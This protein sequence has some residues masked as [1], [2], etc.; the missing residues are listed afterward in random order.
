MFVA[1][2]LSGCL[3]G[4]GEAKDKK[5]GG[6]AEPTGAGAPRVTITDFNAT[7]N[8]STPIQIAWRVGPAGA[9][10]TPGPNNTTIDRTFI[11]RETAVHYAN[12]SVKVVSANS[13]NETDPYGNSSGKRT[14]APAG[15]FST[16]FT[17]NQADTIFARARAVVENRTYWSDEVEIEVLAERPGQVWAVAIGKSGAGPLST[18]DPEPLTIKVGD[19]VLWRNN[20]TARLAHTATSDAGAPASFDTGNVAGGEQSTAIVFRVPGTYSYHCTNHAA[21]MQDAEIIVQA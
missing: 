3:G 8:A 14:D 18:Y 21:T 11:V 12:F 13:T 15:R 20:D 7:V 19:S 17:I 6:T 1:A 2:A 9:N 4:D 5:P 10:Q 16:S